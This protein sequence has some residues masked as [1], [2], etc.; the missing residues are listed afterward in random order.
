MDFDPSREMMFE[1]ITTKFIQ[2]LG[3][4][5]TQLKVMA[6]FI[7]LVV[8]EK[9]EDRNKILRETPMFMCKMILVFPWDPF[10]DLKTTH[11][12]EA[13]VWVDLLMVNPAF[14]DSALELL[15]KVG[16]VVYA[17]SKYAHSNYSN[18]QGCVKVNLSK[19]L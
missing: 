7:F 5:V 3:V 9:A 4:E 10:F 2:D 11:T 1:W 17:T 19:T 6:R 8:L 18:I 12:T 13:L 16:Q 15:G 14:E